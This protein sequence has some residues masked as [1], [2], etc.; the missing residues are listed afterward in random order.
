MKRTNLK[1]LDRMPL[2]VAT[3]EMMMTT[4]RK[5]KKKF[6]KKKKHRNIKRCRKGKKNKKEKVMNIE[7]WTFEQTMPAIVHTPAK[8]IELW[9]YSLIAYRIYINK[10]RPTFLNR[11]INVSHHCATPTNHEQQ[12]GKVLNKLN[13]VV[14]YWTRFSNKFDRP[15]SNVRSF[16][17]FAQTLNPIFIR[18]I[19]NNYFIAIATQKEEKKNNN[20]NKSLNL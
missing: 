20:I 10:M 7:H 9:L 1:R 17:F 14:S 11:N 3:N 5:R 15:I 4:N 8:Y 18:Y 16:A 2:H 12:T 6:K 19:P 13:T